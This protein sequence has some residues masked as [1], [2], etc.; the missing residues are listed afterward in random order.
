MITIEQVASYFTEALFRKNPHGA[1]IEYLQ[2]ELLDSLFKIQGA[3]QLSFI[4]GTA[5]RILYQSVRFSEDL[6]FDS[7]GLSY[8]GFESLLAAACKDMEYKGFSIEYRIVERGAFHCYVRFPEILYKYGLSR[9]RG[10]KILLQVDTELKEKH[11]KPKISILNKFSVFRQIIAAPPGVL[12][13]QKMMAVLYRKREKGRDLFDVSFLA[14]ITEPDF[15]Y[16]KN[17][18]GFKK[19]EFLEVF[20]KRLDELDLKFLARDVEPFLFA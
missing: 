4:G 8:D 10:R 5:I 12:L 15:E 3:Q 13:A 9:E 11:Y 18:L 20:N 16:I 1:L 17:S 7:F 14:G 19:E 2:Y 6:D